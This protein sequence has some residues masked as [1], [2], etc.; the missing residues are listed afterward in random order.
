MVRD[1]YRDG[2]GVPCLVA[3]YQDY[4][5]R[6]LDYALAYAKSIGGTRAGVLMT[7]FKRR[8]RQICLENRQYCVV[9]FQNL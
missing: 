8:Q 7:T 6:A 9:G 4:T 5:G 3:V 2:K 1:Q